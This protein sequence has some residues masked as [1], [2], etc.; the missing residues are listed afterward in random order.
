[1]DEIPV[2]GEN[3]RCLVE[4]LSVV[5]ALGTKGMPVLA[6][7]RIKDVEIVHSAAPFCELMSQESARRSF[8]RPYQGG[9]HCARGFPVVP[10][11]S[12]TG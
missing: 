10:L 4:E 6:V 8:R 9:K 7:K 5:E 3:G 12:T 1:M 11:R 2:C